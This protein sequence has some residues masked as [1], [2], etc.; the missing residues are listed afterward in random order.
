ME[1]KERLEDNACVYVCSLTCS[2][3]GRFGYTARVIPQGDEILKASPGLMTW[4]G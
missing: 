1:I 3:A 2:D 4:A